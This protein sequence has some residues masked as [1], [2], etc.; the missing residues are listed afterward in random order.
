MKDFMQKFGFIVLIFVGIIA[1]IVISQI[2]FTSHKNGFIE[3]INMLEAYEDIDHV[4]CESGNGVIIYVDS[5]W[6]ESQSELQKMQF[7]N[8]FFE[9]VRMAA[10]NN[11]IWKHYSSITTSIYRAGTQSRIILEDVKET[12]NVLIDDAGW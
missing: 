1:W 3:Y 11:K 5:A 6:W 9:C 2:K 12:E 8:D 4:Y 7:A 10:N